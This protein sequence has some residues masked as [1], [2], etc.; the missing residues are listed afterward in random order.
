VNDVELVGN[1]DHLS[2]PTGPATPMTNPSCCPLPLSG[3]DPEEANGLHWSIMSVHGI[4]THHS[5]ASFIRMADQRQT[6]RRKR[7]TLTV[8]DRLQPC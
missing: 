7:P 5:P 6:F 8:I 1:A 4:H 3:A 2:Q